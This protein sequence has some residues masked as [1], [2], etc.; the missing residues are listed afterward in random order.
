MELAKNQCLCP[1]CRRVKSYSEPVRKKD[2]TT[3]CI[4]CS[5]KN[6]RKAK[7]R[8]KRTC[9]TCGEEKTSNTFIKATTC[10]NCSRKKVMGDIVFLKNHDYVKVHYTYICHECDSVRVLSTK[11]KSSYCKTCARLYTK[12][13]RRETSIYFDFEDMKMRVPNV[14]HYRVCECGHTAQVASIR[15]ACFVKEC[16]KCKPKSIKEVVK[17]QLK[18]PKRKSAT[19]AKIAIAKVVEVNR[20]H[21]EDMALCAKKKPVIPKAKLTNEEML[22]IW[23]KDNKPSVIMEKNPEMPF[24]NS[25]SSL[26]TNPYF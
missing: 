12:K 10:Q 18:E 7:G 3:P 5:G 26:C 15:N 13:R 1:Q 25:E 24:R 17:K 2:L 22:A 14:K 8:F 4:K 9:D 6:R 20:K 16:V 21:K 23:E 11:R 19:P